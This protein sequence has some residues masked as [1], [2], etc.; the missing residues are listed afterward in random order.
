MSKLLKYA[1]YIIS[2]VV[3][4]FV[5]LVIAVSVLVDPNDYK[6]VI[7]DKVQAATGRNLTI[8]GDLT[9][10]FFP[11]FGIEIGKTELG[12]APGFE[13]EVFAKIEQVAV[14]V[15]VLPLLRK[16]L[17]IDKVILD[18]LSV[19]LMRNA[20]GI[21]NWDDLA[22]LAAAQGKSKQKQS[23]GKDARQAMQEHHD[24]M[25][26]KMAGLDIGG[27]LIS[28]AHLEWDDRKNRVSWSLRD[29]D[30][31]IG[32]VAIDKPVS[33][34]LKVIAT[35]KKSNKDYPV[36][37]S[38]VLSMNHDKHQMQLKDLEL[39]LSGLRLKGEVFMSGE[40]FQVTGKLASNEFVPRELLT[41]LGI[42]LPA[43]QDATVFGKASF[44]AAINMTANSLSLD[45]LLVKLDDTSIK[46]NVKVSPI[47]SAS[48]HFELAIDELDADRYLPAAGK[49]AEKPAT[50]HH[51][52]SAG[53]EDAP[54]PIPVKMLRGLD[55][56]GQLKIG[57]LKAYGI[58]SSDIRMTL[59]A[60]KGL[61]KISPVTAKLY[62]GVYTGNIKMNVHGKTPVFSINEQLTGVQ[63]APLLKDVADMKLLSGRADTS[64][65]VTTRG[66]NITQLRKG[67]NGN[68]TFNF[69]DGAIEGVNVA[70]L[71][72]KTKAALSGAPQPAEAPEKTDFS[73]LT[74]TAKIVNGVIQNDDLFAT[75]PLLRIVGK[76]Q[77]DLVKEQINYRLETVVVATLKGQGGASLDKL[78]GVPIPVKISGPL[79]DPKF[80]V[81]LGKVLTKQ[82]KTKLKKKLK[83]EKNRAKQKLKDLLKF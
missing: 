37:L 17:V 57:K 33:I 35:D 69:T 46:G 79:R 61:I 7:T 72:R 48:I 70:H 16:Q 66:N 47:S 55:I 27:I 77:I 39:G 59:S 40:D 81:E 19:H 58:R 52:A 54:L 62:D 11:W 73:S 2:L 74:G 1:L 4:L 25:D 23:S 41:G 24:S 80:K 68:M 65:K 51:A 22:A 20:Q 15:Q 18:G 5:G 63:A 36:S 49:V 12:N 29:M 56:R 28:N 78:K 13:G 34:K 75:S 38:T 32:A 31:A 44:A 64:V 8:E 60:D 6:D 9:L 43:T 71:L 21:T 26:G 67:L 76:G 45:S 30:L 42:G 83:K 10:N 14:N 53:S 3:I 82:Q 50:Q